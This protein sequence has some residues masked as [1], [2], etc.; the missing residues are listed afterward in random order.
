[1]KYCMVNCVIKTIKTDDNANTLK[2]GFI[3]KKFKKVKYE[4]KFY[5]Q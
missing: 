2:I 1:M 3:F 5:L 4:T